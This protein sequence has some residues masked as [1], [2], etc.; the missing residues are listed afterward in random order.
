MWPAFDSIRDAEAR[1]H[2]AKEKKKI[3]SVIQS[4]ISGRTCPITGEE[5]GKGA[6]GRR[7]GGGRGLYIA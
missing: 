7:E 2:A 4:N 5:K 3:I 6:G 1:A